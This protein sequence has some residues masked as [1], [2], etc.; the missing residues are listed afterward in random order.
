MPAQKK[1][2]HLPKLYTDLLCCRPVPGC[3]FDFGLYFF[4]NARELLSRG[5]GPY[6]YL[7]KMQSHLEARL[8]NEV[9]LDAQ[10]ILGIPRGTIKVPKACPQCQYSFCCGLVCRWVLG[11]FWGFFLE[12]GVEYNAAC[13]RRPCWA[14]RPLR[15]PPRHHQGE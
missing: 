4:H 11:G 15:D 10:A 13:V 5:S 14:P 9:F 6:F 2:L 7:P 8:W 12:G 3:L 1:N